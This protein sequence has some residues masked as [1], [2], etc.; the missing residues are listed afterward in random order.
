MRK[1]AGVIRLRILRGK[2]IP[3]ILGGPSVV[4]RVL[5]SWRQE[6]QSPRRMEQWRHAWGGAQPENVSS[7]EKLEEARNRCVLRAFARKGGADTCEAPQVLLASALCGNGFVLLK[8]RSSWSWVTAAIA[9]S[10]M[11]REK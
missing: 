5:G 10:C 9:N 3:D 4:I 1:F 7:L 6:G 8:V 11:C 2:M